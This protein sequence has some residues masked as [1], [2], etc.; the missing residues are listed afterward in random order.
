MVGASLSFALMAACIKLADERGAPLGQVLFYRSFGSLVL[1]YG[2]LRR[3][4]VPLAS[5]HWRRH[6]VRGVTSFVSMVVLFSAIRMLPL[7]TAITLNFLAPVILAGLLVLVHAERPTSRLSGSLACAVAGVVLLLKP[8]IAADQWAGALVGLASAV[9]AAIAMLNLRAIGRLDE[10]PWRSVYYFSLIASLLALPWYLAS[11]PLQVDGATL[12]LMLVAAVFATG[13]QVLQ[14]HA[15]E[16]R[17]T[18]FISLLGY[19]QVLFSSAIGVVL[20]HNRPTP[21]W[22]AGMLLVIAA[23]ASAVRAAQPGGGPPA[24]MAGG[25]AGRQRQ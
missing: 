7:A 14:T 22:W 1:V 21:G 20:F 8:T 10:P 6:L 19:S 17:N 9:L 23:G 5:P 3:T 18:L 12:G 13:G 2:Y 16:H 4:R 11:R 15:Y 25:S 24:P